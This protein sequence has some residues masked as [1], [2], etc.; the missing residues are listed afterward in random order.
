MT[1]ISP[2]SRVY[3]SKYMAKGNKNPKTDHLK[4]F[5]FKKGQSGNP[6]GRAVGKSLKEYTRE[7]FKNMSEEERNAYLNKLMKKNPEIIW[8]MSEGNPAQDNETTIKVETPTPI[9]DLTQ[10]E[11]IEGDTQDINEEKDA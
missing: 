9:L 6:K 11:M 10:L 4:P 5:Q 7:Y 1:V 2:F 3:Y 8:R